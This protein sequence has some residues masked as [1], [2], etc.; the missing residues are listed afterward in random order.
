M[1]SSPSTDRRFKDDAWKEN[2]VFDFIRQSYLLSARYINDVVSHVD[3]LEPKT[4]QK[5]G[6]YSRQ[7]AD[8]KEPR[9][10]SS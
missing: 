6:L 3:G 9:R 2:E 1:I 10:T 7:F 5:R 8:A 4:A